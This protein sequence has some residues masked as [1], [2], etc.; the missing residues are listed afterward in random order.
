MKKAVV[1]ISIALLLAA[2]CV[3]VF[4]GSTC[5]CLSDP[6][7]P[8]YERREVGDFIVRFYDDYCEIEG[9][10][11]QGNSQRFLV[12]P[13]Y[14]EGVKVRSF[15]TYNPFSI[16]STDLF[17]PQI[18]SDILEKIY[19]EVALDN[20][21]P[22][23][24][25][26]RSLKKILYPSMDIGKD[27]VIDC[28][29]YYP[30]KAYEMVNGDVYSTGTKSRTRANI[31]YYYNYENAKN[32][33]YYWIDDCDYGSIIE[34]IPPDPERDDYVFGGWYKEPECINE[35]D[36]DDDKLPEEKKG[37]RETY[38]DG[39]FFLSEVTIYQETI[40]YAKWEPDPKGCE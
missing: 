28:Q 32:D 12:I 40:L 3:F 30:R 27:S 14:I 2:L 23:L 16:A 24:G 9:T 11:E 38:E 10:T 7:S 18:N 19:F 17:A 26:I 34:F 21:Y 15:G 13:E 35:W 22:W 39:K 8:H 31:S 29:A 5:T 37:I 25:S 4:T 36:F 6:E 33:G 20:I 1:K